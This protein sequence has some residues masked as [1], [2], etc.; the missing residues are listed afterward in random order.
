[1]FEV[2]DSPG[3]RV[4]GNTTDRSGEYSLRL[5]PWSGRF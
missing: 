5:L 1:M 4:A 2:C 3:E